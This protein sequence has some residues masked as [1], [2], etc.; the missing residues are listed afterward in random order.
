MKNHY[1]VIKLISWYRK[2]VRSCLLSAFHYNFAEV[3]DIYKPKIRK[4]KQRKHY[5]QIPKIKQTKLRSESGRGIRDTKNI[6]ETKNWFLDL[7]NDVRNTGSK[8]NYLDRKEREKTENTLKV[9]IEREKK[10]CNLYLL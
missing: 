8:A 4:A 1:Y 5:K 9:K 10:A 7:K 6:L 2:N 3:I